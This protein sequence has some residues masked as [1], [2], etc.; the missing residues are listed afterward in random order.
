M[1]N[2][3]C[4]SLKRHRIAINNSSQLNWVHPNDQRQIHILLDC[5]SNLTHV[6]VNVNNF[7]ESPDKY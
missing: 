3:Y 7:I 6:A 2:N 5:N 1:K 4:N